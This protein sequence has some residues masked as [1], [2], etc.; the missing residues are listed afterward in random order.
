MHPEGKVTHAPALQI[1]QSK[2]AA[3]FPSMPFRYSQDLG[4]GWSGSEG[5]LERRWPGGFLVARVGKTSVR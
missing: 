5:G 4:C 3:F 1:G 2:A